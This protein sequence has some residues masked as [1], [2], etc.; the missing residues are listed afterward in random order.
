MSNMIQFENKT[1]C[2]KKQ[3]VS[4]L[5]FCHYPVTITVGDKTETFH[6]FDDAREWLDSIVKDN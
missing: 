5:A 4:A 2:D 1:Y 6:S 3:A